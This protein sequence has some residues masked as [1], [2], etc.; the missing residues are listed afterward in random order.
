MDALN[1]TTEELK[2]SFICEFNRIKF[3]EER[4]RDFLVEK[5]GCFKGAE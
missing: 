5:R 1:T 2:P 3:D 4:L